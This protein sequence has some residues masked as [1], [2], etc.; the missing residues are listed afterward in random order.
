M[1]H[2]LWP[3]RIWLCEDSKEVL[4]VM[5]RVIGTIIFIIFALIV[6]KIVGILALTF[7]GSLLGLLVLAIKLAIIGGI[8]YLIWLGVRKLVHTV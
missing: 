2:A 3:L 1:K 5:A 6:L 7:L 8:I 4:K